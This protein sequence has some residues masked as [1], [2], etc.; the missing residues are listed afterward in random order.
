MTC[1]SIIIAKHTQFTLILFQIYLYIKILK[2]MASV[3][4]Y[5]SS[6]W[7]HIALQI[8][9]FLFH[10]FR[11]N[12]VDGSKSKRSTAKICKIITIVRVSYMMFIAYTVRLAI[13]AIIISINLFLPYL[14][15][16]IC[17]F[18]KRTELSVIILGRT[19][20]HLFIAMR[21]RLSTHSLKS[22]YYKIGLY[23][24]FLDV[25]LFIYMSS[26]LFTNINVKYIDYQCVTVNITPIV[27]LWLLFNDLFIGIYSLFAFVLP[28]RRLINSTETNKENMNDLT[29]LIKKIIIYSIIALFVTFFLIL[30]TVMTPRLGA[31][32]SPVSSTVTIY[33]IIM[34]FSNIKLKKLKSP[35]L[36][37]I[38][39]MIQ[40]S[41]KELY[42]LKH[43]NNLVM[44]NEI[45]VGRN[46]KHKENEKTGN[47]MDDDVSNFETSKTQIPT[48]T[49]FG[50]DTPTLPN[51]NTQMKHVPSTTSSQGR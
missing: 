34:Q 24:I 18:S 46:N 33:C 47:K 16:D 37:I 4:V 2:T 15:D 11:L 22:K 9:M 43:E 21:S 42:Q 27:L 40:C 3:V 29:K 44:M 23:F 13:P 50:Y 26:P 51:G 30:F 5:L 14:N 10:Y 36:R 6:E 49:T 35:Y 1:A 48:P 17:Y 8:V 41:Y 28:L 12:L 19:L 38:I 25:L 39:S 20:V 45:T 32:L 7:I 31:F